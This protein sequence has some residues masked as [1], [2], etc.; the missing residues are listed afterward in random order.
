VSSGRTL[1]L[2]V[3]FAISKRLATSDAVT[4][5]SLLNVINENVLSTQTIQTLKPF[6]G[7]RLAVVRDQ[8]DSQKPD[9][10]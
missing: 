2:Q 9:D 6:I 7:L 8:R 1:L 5:F 3:P 10:G 4:Y